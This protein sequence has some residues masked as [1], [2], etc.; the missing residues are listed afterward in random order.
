M[1]VCPP[2]PQDLVT[3]IGWSLNGKIED[4]HVQYNGANN[5]LL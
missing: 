2:K 1:P 4:S 5:N 3:T